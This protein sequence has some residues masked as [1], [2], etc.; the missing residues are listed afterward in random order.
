MK[1][2]TFGIVV[3]VYKTKKEYLDECVF[4][5][6]NQSYSNIKIV[7]VDDCSPD[8]CGF[9]CEDYKKMDSR[10]DVIHHTNNK[11]LPGARNSGI[12][13]LMNEVD[14]IMFVDS[15]DWIDLNCIE[16]LN[17]YID[18]WNNSPDMIVFTGSKDY[19][20]KRVISEKVF[21]N[22]SWFC[23]PTEITNFQIKSLKYIW[24]DYP[25]SALNLDSACWR[26]CASSLFKNNNLRFEDIP[27]RE[28]GLFFLYSTEYSNKIVYI[29]ETF[30]HYRT[31]NGSM[32]NSY[33][34]SADK[35]H[36]IY[37]NQVDRFS[38]TFNKSDS[39]VMLTSYLAL[40]SM[41]I[42][43]VQKF[44]NKE[45]KKSF[46][47]KQKECS[48]Y[49]KTSPFCHVFS[50]IKISN[51]RKNHRIKAYLIKFH[52]YFMIPLLLKIYNKKHQREAF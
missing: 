23:G 51:L 45:N 10:I 37:L 34:P 44:F 22:E 28:D 1:K 7:L 24:K 26:I 6:I 17:D 42:C 21:D 48:R 52:L 35:E 49:F 29:Y 13:K 19:P 43:I 8:E 2:N 50:R 16:K 11:G 39:F 5:I 30:Y 40:L 15:D 3:P 36:H 38:K 33:R 12:L 9:Y 32:V 14:W 4:S 31:T 18:S 41:E 46:F 25:S 47:S 20:S 27:Y